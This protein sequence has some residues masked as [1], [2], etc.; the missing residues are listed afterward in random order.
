MNHMSSGQ[1]RIDEASLH[2]VG[3][4]WTGKFDGKEEWGRLV[5]PGNAKRALR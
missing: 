4:G 5:L 1:W 3:Q 2:E